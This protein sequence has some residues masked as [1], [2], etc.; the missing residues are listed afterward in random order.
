ML[1]A[2]ANAGRDCP[3]RWR[4]E[5]PALDCGIPASRKQSPAIECEGESGDDPLV[6]LEDRP[7]TPAATSQTTT[8]LRYPA[9]KEAGVRART[10]GR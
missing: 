10:R 3:A 2:L 9:G 8:S 4:G 6:A 7:L 5:V 1:T